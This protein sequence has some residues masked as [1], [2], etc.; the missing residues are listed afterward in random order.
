MPPI[1]MDVRGRC[2]RILTLAV[3]GSLP[4]SGLIPPA[5][6]QSS[7]LFFP[8][9]FVRGV[10]QLPLAGVT[11][12]GPIQSVAA[13]PLNL[14][15]LLAA[16][17][18]GGLF[19][20][21]D[22]GTTWSHVD[23][24]PVSDLSAVA[25]NQDA[26]LIL[27]TARN[28][29]RR[30][31][32]RF[33]LSNGAGIWSS[34]DGGASWRQV[35]TVLASTVRVG[36]TKSCRTRPMA[37]GIAVDPSSE[38]IFVATTCGLYQSRNKGV[39]FGFGDLGDDADG[40]PRTFYSVAVV[41]PTTALP[42]GAVVAG[43]PDG[44]FYLDGDGPTASLRAATGT[45]GLS[46]HGSDGNFRHAITHS[47]SRSFPQDVLATV[48]PTAADTE[49]AI[50]WSRDG[51]RTWQTLPG[52]SDTEYSPNCGGS[53]F[54]R[55]SP[56]PGAVSMFL[57]YGNRCH[58]WRVP[59]PGEDP[60][61]L[62]DPD[63]S[64]RP[65]WR[66]LPLQHPDP[67]ESLVVASSLIVATDGGIEICSEYP[68]ACPEGGVRGAAAGLNALQ[69]T[70]VSGQ[71]I[72]DWPESRF[73]EAHLYSRPGTRACGRPLTAGTI[74]PPLEVEKATAWKCLASR[75]GGQTRLLV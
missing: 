53:P 18:T 40:T 17:Q 44:L 73:P 7:L 52:P 54:V 55:T 9:V 24:L 13:N 48:D 41:P 25:Y 63:E 45:I 29:W 67:H 49:P 28:D 33:G 15:E 27:V 19:K 16:S 59:L 20:S 50:V 36:R 42:T 65:G 43:G 10:R 1:G 62:L 5:S 47:E 3:L 23:A 14:N 30:V 37:F 39:S 26:S 75:P 21:I 71:K 70:R 46:S 12:G 11:W 38:R 31:S 56:E 35:R 68:L 66:Q 8:D 6:A 4:A 2:A 57:Y 22:G 61:V 69:A 60:A 72:I 32:D 74:G 64:K 34:D 58:V 51:G